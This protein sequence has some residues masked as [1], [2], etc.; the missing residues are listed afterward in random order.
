MT[1]LDARSGVVRELRPATLPA[2]M[3]DAL[4]LVES[5]ISDTTRWSCWPS[6]PAAAGC[7]FW[8]E[9]AAEAAALG[10]A[11]ERYCGNL[12]PPGLLTASYTQLDRAAVAAIDP[13][14]LALYTAEQ[15]KTPGFPFVPFT[16]DLEV[17]W[18]QGREIRTGSPCQ[19]PSSLVWVTYLRAPLTESEPRT[20]PTI[21]AGI[22]AGPTRAAA[23]QS[24]LLELLERDAVAIGW[25]SGSPIKEVLP[26][27]WLGQLAAGPERAFRAR[28][29][30]FPSLVG[31]PV[32]GT[33]LV[34]EPTGH[35]ALGTACRATP[36]EAAMK[37]LAEAFQ[38]HLV[39]RQLDDPTSP[40]CRL[41]TTPNSPLKPWR[42]DRRY[43]LAYRQDRRDA[44]DLGCHLQLHLDPAVRASLDGAFQPS[45]TSLLDI[46]SADSDVNALAGRLL[47]A[48]GIS[49]ISVD[50]TTADVAAAGLSVVRLVA[51]G[52]YSN[53][54]AAMPYLGGTRL[55]AEMD[56][57]GGGLRWE[58][59]PY[60]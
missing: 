20:N 17:R 45:T 14:S 33:L 46:P 5:V 37:A 40:L 51:P 58:P 19:V 13:C 49:V 8:D 36:L 47:A 55:A 43:G 15:Y 1:L 2:D 3:P 23:E 42:A 28:F 12:V 39:V 41:A 59:L 54:P 57:C 38:L 50:V 53:A 30:H 4:Y 29:L 27:T 25:I 7:A 26:A 32:I 56:R 48:A 6:D 9:H 34:H 44:T 21:Y 18:S 22:A 60:G 24:A 16:R 31:V 52:L 10:E 35:V 11:V